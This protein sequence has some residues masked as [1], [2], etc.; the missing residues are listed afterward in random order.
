VIKTAHSPLKKSAEKLSQERHE[1]FFS[2]HFPYEI[3]MMR[4]AYHKLKGE[5]F[6]QGDQNAMI[7]TFCIHA[8]NIIELF[9]THVSCDFDPRYF[10]TSD[11]RINKQFI[12]DGL[13]SKINNQISH[14]TKGRTELHQYKIGPTDRNEIFESI[15]AEIARFETALSDTRKEKWEAAKITW[16]FPVPTIFV[17]KTLEATNFSTSSHLITGYTGAARPQSA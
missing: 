10:T 5:N 6:D 8:R 11:F 1:A 14:L 7:E 3:G 17:G 15:E 2:E 12:K 13:L 16:T 4:Y 9:K